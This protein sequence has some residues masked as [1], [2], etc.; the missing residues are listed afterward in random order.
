MWKR[1]SKGKTIALVAVGGVSVFMGLY[2]I[3]LLIAVF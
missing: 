1:I 2:G 3:P